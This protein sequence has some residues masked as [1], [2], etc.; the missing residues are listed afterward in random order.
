MINIL[1]NPLEASMSN[2]ESEIVNSKKGAC[3][4]FFVEQKKVPVP[5][6]SSFSITIRTTHFL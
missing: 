4:F 1:Q 6:F 2:D 3:P 5:S